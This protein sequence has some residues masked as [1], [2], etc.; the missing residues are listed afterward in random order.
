MK[1]LVRLLKVIALVLAC[2]GGFLAPHVA[3][4]QVVIDHLSQGQEIEHRTSTETTPEQNQAAANAPVTAARPFS[5]GL[6]FSPLGLAVPFKIGASVAWRFN[7]SW[8]GEIGYFYGHFGFGSRFLDLASFTESLTNI[9]LRYFPSRS[10]NWL[11]GLNNQTYDARIG[12][13]LLGRV[14]GGTVPSGIDVLRVSTLGLQLGLGNRWEL[15]NGFLIGIDWLVLNIPLQTLDT[16]APYLDYV[17]NPDDRQSVD[18]FIR[19]MRFLPTGALI[20][21]TLGWT[22]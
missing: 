6:S 21:L 13:L 12:S 1:K 8:V 11:I 9:Q 3:I 20:K 10:F 14:S 4:A 17:S 7:A 22:F 19:F 16:H 5:A 18:D 15:S 2:S